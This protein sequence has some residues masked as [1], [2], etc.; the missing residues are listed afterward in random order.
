MI[1]FLF[2]ST[3]QPCGVGV[4]IETITCLA[5]WGHVSYLEHSLFVLNRGFT[6]SVFTVEILHSVPCN[7][8]QQESFPWYNSPIHNCLSGLPICCG[9]IWHTENAAEVLEASLEGLPRQLQPLPTQVGQTFHSESQTW[10]PASRV[11]GDHCVLPGI[12]LGSPAPQPGW[13]SP[14]TKARMDLSPQP[15]NKPPHLPRDAGITARTSRQQGP[16][17]KGRG[18][19]SI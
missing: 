14:Q 16:W 12:S 11:P 9:D 4:V 10:W 7:S 13:P 15:L 3:Q 18:L 19:S 2:W 1:P 17:E 6:F 8:A 5:W